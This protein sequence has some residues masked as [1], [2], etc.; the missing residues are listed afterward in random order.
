MAGAWLPGAEYVRSPHD[1]GGQ[2]GGA[3]RVVWH[4]TESDPK[5]TPAL[6]AAR[7]LD[8]TGYTPHLVWNPLTG[9]VV[10]LLPA[11]RAAR[12]LRG[13][14]DELTPNRE[15]RVCLQ[16]EV[17]GYSRYPFTTQPLR[18]LADILRW[19]DAWQVPR[20]WP[21]GP[22]PAEPICRDTPRDRAHWARG[23]HFGH[24]QVP[25]TAHFD[26]GALDVSKLV[27]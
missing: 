4:T 9:E 13:P 19:L 12:G 24:S 11:T 16:I 10:Q 1:G 7:H 15:G 14:A 27:A 2:A 8:H 23:G 26:P 22:P 3:P 18:G 5:E 20:R 6:L 17:I 25:G 21:A